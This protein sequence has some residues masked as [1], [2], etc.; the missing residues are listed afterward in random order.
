MSTTIELIDQRLNS[1]ITNGKD[2][3]AGSLRELKQA[4]LAEHTKD[5][6]DRL[7]ELCR[8]AIQVCESG[9]AMYW[10][11]DWRESLAKVKA[12]L[13]KEEQS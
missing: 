10:H 7:T 6:A 13:A 1:A 8:R 9:A 5:K 11:P 12:D 4:I 3:A 2:E